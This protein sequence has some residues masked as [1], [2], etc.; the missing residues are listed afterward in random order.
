MKN[1]GLHNQK[2]VV[3]VSSYQGNNPLYRKGYLKVSD[4]HR[5]LMYGDGTPF[6]WIGDTAWA[7]PMH[8]TTQEWQTYIQDRRDK[9]FFRYPNLLLYGKLDRKKNQQQRTRA[10]F[11][12]RH[13]AM[14]SD[15]L[16]RLRKHGSVR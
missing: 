3:D 1:T 9:R 13:R 14:E 5:Y 2:G 15:V 6:L 8:A 12:E 4:D 11:G 16:A 10:I 7:A